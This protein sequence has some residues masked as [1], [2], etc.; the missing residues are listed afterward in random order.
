ME[1]TDIRDFYGP[2][3]GVKASW[4]VS[5]VK[6]LGDKKRIEV[7]VVCRQGMVWADPDTRQQAHTN[8]R[9]A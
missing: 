6:I 8:S 1:V 7:R 5:E 2:L 9:R 4:S 3:P